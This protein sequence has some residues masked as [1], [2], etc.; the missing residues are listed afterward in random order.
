MSKHTSTRTMISNAP[1][2]DEHSNSD[3]KDDTSQIP[4]LHPSNFKVNL[5][6][7]HSSE[8][9]EQVERIGDQFCGDYEM[10]EYSQDEPGELVFHKDIPLKSPP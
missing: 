6:V 7:S 9:I 2:I 5:S 8:S 1:S 10:H 4:A 3:I